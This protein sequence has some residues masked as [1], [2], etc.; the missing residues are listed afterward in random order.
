MPF[1]SWVLNEIVYFPWNLINI[2]LLKGQLVGCNFCIKMRRYLIHLLHL[3]NNININTFWSQIY[4]YILVIRCIK[5][6]LQLLRIRCVQGIFRSNNKG[7]YKYKCN[8]ILL[9]FFWSSA[10]F[11]F[12]NLSSIWF[13]TTVCEC[14]R[15][16]FESFSLYWEN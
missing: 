6:W 9:S 12:L 7:N 14:P 5:H 1:V 10:K 3:K 8:E 16:I 13:S 11:N 15:D 2:Y 4:H